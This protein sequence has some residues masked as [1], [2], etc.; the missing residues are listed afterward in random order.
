MP[1]ALAFSDEVQR[2]AAAPRLFSYQHF[3]EA[4]FLDKRAK[5]RYNNLCMY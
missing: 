2:Y 3:S 4:V 1:P 5:E